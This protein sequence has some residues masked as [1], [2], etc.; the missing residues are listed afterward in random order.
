MKPTNT[1]LIGGVAAAVLLAGVGGF[2]LAKLTSA[3]PAPSAAEGA[4]TEADHSS[5]GVTMTGEAIQAA[6][7]VV[8]PVGAGGLASE[9]LAQAIVT[10]T[11]NGQAVLTARA[12]G[13]V[14]RIFKRLGDPVQVGEVLAIVESRD[15]AQIA[16]DRSVAAA[17]A[18]MAH[19]TLARE[20]SLYDQR[21]SPR[22]DYE[23]AL[24]EATVADAGAR[25]A[26]A[27]AGVAKVTAD[28]RGVMVVSP[29]SGRIT[30]APASL[31]AFVQSE[32]ELF[33]VADPELIQVEAAVR[34][35]DAIRIAP[36]DRAVIETPDGTALDARVRSVTPGLDAQTRS[37]TALLE[38]LSG[39]LQPGQSARVRI[40]PKAAAVGSAIVVPEEAV[41][42]LGGREVVFVRTSM[43]FEPRS[44]MVGQRS[45]GR[46]EIASGLSAGAV[47]A[48]R[49]A[50][51]LKAELGKSEGEEH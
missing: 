39:R 6:G 36:G 37:A 48:T 2:G 21:V 18:G 50:F 47:I 38:L 17:K 46:V 11:P 1:R 41:Q 4:K 19:R 34:G 12:S 9:I 33:R 8:Q 27:A 5:E 26:Q 7:I 3:K 16:A 23:Q 42:S 25:R 40:F 30:A 29:I 32:T 20:K 31:G 28:G 22:V 24:A 51:L 44:V 13:A 14:T 43:G 15:A 49:N 10:P 45:A 35:D